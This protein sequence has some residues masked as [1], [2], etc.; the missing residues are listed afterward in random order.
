M[1]CVENCGTPAASATRRTTLDQVHELSGSAWL[2]RDSH[3][4][5]G[6]LLLMVARRARW[7]LTRPAGRAEQGTLRPQRVFVVSARTRTVRCAGSRSSVGSEQSSPRR[8][9]GVVG[10]GEHQPVADGLVTKDGKKIQPLLLGP[11]QLHEP[12]D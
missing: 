3:R 2:R 6:P 10:E 11:R 4:K 1:V 8:T 9:P 12:R 7:R 5:S